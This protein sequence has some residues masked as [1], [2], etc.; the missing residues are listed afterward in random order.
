MGKVRGA[1][2]RVISQDESLNDTVKPKLFAAK[3]SGASVKTPSK[4]P[5]QSMKRVF[6]PFTAIF[7]PIGVVEV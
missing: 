3:L 2:P 5:S 4:P 6:D 7:R 1:A